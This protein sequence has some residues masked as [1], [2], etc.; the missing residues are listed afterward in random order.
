[1]TNIKSLI[2]KWGMSSEL[3]EAL[4]GVAQVERLGGEGQ[5]KYS[6]SIRYELGK[7]SRLYSER[8]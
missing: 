5:P 6:L 1:M 3:E 2:L 4:K 8:I 7:S